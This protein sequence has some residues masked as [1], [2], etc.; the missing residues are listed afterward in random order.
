MKNRGQSGRRAKEKRKVC[1]LT[2]DATTPKPGLCV[3]KDGGLTK[4]VAVWFF[5]CEPEFDCGNNRNQNSVYREEGNMCGEMGNL[6]FQ[7]PFYV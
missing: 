4:A 1:L 5:E 6:V 7:K 3:G 2:V